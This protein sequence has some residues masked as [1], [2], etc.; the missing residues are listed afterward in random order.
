MKQMYFSYYDFVM[1]DF[2][3]AG[4]YLL[5]TPFYIVKGCIWDGPVYLYEAAFATDHP[6]DDKDLPQTINK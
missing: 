6:D 4:Y 1:N 5:A 2:R 3:Y